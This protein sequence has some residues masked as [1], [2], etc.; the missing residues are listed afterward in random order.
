L[1][2]FVEIII[3]ATLLGVVFGLISSVGLGLT[4]AISLG[5]AAGISFGLVVGIIDDAVE[6]YVLAGIAG[7]MVVTGLLDVAGG[8]AGNATPAGIIAGIV[9]GLAAGFT[10][11]LTLGNDVADMVM[12][13][14][15]GMTAGITVS[16]RKARPL[17]GAHPRSRSL[18]VAAI[19]T[20]V[21]IILN[22]LVGGLVFAGTFI[23]FFYRL[24][25]YLVSAFS[26]W[27]AQR[28]SRRDPSH[29]FA[30]LHASS[31][32][33]D[34]HVYLPL[35]GLRGMLTIAAQQSIDRTLEE[36]SFIVME[37]PLQ[38]D[39][40]RFVSLEIAFHDLEMRDTLRY[41]AEASVRLSEIFPHG[42]GL[43]DP[44]WAMVLVRLHDASQ[45][46]AQAS[47]PI[48][49]QAKH[50]A[51]EAM[52]VDLKQ[53]HPNTAFN[54]VEMNRR[55]ANIVTLWQEAAVRELRILEKAPERTRR[56]SN[57]YNPGPALER[58]N[59]LFVGRYDIAA[60]VGEALTRR[61]HRPTFLLYGERRMGKSSVLKHL[62]DLLGAR[63]MPVFYDLQSPDSTSSIAAFLGMIAEEIIVVMET[64]GLKARKLEYERLK[65]A[66]RENEAAVY[67]VFNRWLRGI[68]KI[69]EQKDRTLLLVFDEFEKLDAAGKEHYLNLELLLNLFRSIM[70]HHPR[71]FLLFS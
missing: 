29:V 70:Q 34:E 30:Y 3:L 2:N 5:L 44:Q 68:E 36:V 22:G 56:I 47:S 21:F 37:R 57:P 59:K 38:I 4:G 41:I 63:F 53:M 50:N 8:K 66:R 12:G 51:L 39:A 69:L 25:L 1:T 46:A 11:K 67:Y 26:S 16:R 17:G 23:I 48:G 43:I 65:E 62:P 13:C 58:Y 54:D 71:V 42:T 24:P 10:A 33:W 18:L 20:G 64:R 49:W 60:Q 31:L 15:V 28:A 14:M 55:L 19:L 35:P 9:A 6:A 27:Q 7:G 32:Y 45:D 52:L 40:A 61:D